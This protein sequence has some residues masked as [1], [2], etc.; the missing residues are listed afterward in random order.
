MLRSSVGS[1]GEMLRRYRQA[2]RLTQQELAE[3]AGLSVHG[4]QKLE[5]GATHP[6]RDTAQRLIVALALDPD[7]ETRFRASVAPVHRHNSAPRSEVSGGTRHNLPLVLPYATSCSTDCAMRISVMSNYCSVRFPPKHTA[8]SI[9]RRRVVLWRCVLRLRLVQHV[10]DRKVGG[11]G[12]ARRP[13][14]RK[15]G[16]TQYLAGMG[17]C[18]VERH[19]VIRHDGNG[20]RAS[21]PF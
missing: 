9:S 21:Q 7:A 17:K 16:I 14:G 11:H 6:Y 2:A 12:I 8:T 18:R 5:R 15:S 10:G 3:R 13:R 20:Q 4:I 19:A 1:F